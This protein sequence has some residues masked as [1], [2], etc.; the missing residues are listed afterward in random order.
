MTE[1]NVSF[2]AKKQSPRPE[3]RD[4]KYVVLKQSD[5]PEL[6]G[7]LF[8]GEAPEWA[9]DDVMA[10]A[11]EDALVVRTQDRFS[12]PILHTWASL[13]TAAIDASSDEELKAQLLVVA[14][15]LA[16]RAR[17]ADELFYSGEA[18]YPS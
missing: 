8:G 14:D 10:Y 2:L 1:N 11:L 15:Y 4:K 17:E 5:L 9:V 13:I 7:E 6:M 12:G 18:K 16:D 3:R